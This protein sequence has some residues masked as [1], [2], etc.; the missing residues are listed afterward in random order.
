VSYNASVVQFYNATNTKKIISHVIVNSKNWR[1]S[2]K[3][4]CYNPNLAKISS[5]L[6]KSPVLTKKLAIEN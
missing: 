6:K 1:F 3:I 5:I 4:Q 2:L